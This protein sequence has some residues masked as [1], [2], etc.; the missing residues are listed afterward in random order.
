MIQ[1]DEGTPASCSE[2]WLA[3]ALRLLTNCC[4][5]PLGDGSAHP[6]RAQVVAKIS[7]SLLINMMNAPKYQTEAVSLVYNIGVDDGKS[8]SNI[9]NPMLYTHVNR[10][11]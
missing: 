1:V 9:A 4:G 10:N 6:N 5:D 11:F 8:N 2:T 7:I 3:S